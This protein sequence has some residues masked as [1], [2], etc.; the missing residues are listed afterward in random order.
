MHLSRPLVISEPL[1]ERKCLLEGRDLARQV[2]DHHQQVSETDEQV[3][4]LALATAD[5]P[6]DSDGALP[7]SGS[8]FPGRQV[9]RGGTRPKGILD[10]LGG[11]ARRARQTVVNGESRD[12]LLTVDLLDRLRGP[13][14][15]AVASG[16]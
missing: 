9:A 12:L 15:A 16:R 5:T 10:R 8:L 6:E 14:A 13:G 1:V 4:A 11:I 2:S 7:V 3:S